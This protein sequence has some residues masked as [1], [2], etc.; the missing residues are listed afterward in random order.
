MLHK[1]KLMNGFLKLY[2]LLKF[3]YILTYLILVEEFEFSVPNISLADLSKTFNYTLDFLDKM[4]LAY[5][6]SG[7]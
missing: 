1:A 4:L 6:A 2:I 7:L 5:F 3:L